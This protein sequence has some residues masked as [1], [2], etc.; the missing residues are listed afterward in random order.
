MMLRLRRAE[1]EDASRVFS[2]RNDETVRRVSID[3]REIAREEH[4]D[5][6]RRSIGRADRSLLIA[7]DG[8]IPVGVLRFDVVDE[9]AEISIFLNPEL[10]G[11][12]YGTAML[13]EGAIWARQNL[14]GVKTLRAK[15]RPDNP[16]SSHA[17]EK[18]GFVEVWHVYDLNL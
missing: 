5:W 11:R 17:F 6:F 8:E 12:G 7:E 9:V 4:S 14:M 15:I 3:P 13:R 18:A 1:E 16:A 2:W 10:V